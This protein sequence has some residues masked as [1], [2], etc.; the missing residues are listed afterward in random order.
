MEEGSHADNGTI[1][2]VRTND[3]YIEPDKGRRGGMRIEVTKMRPRI[4]R[5]L[6]QTVEM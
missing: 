5:A 6:E 1:F 2:K 4:L 3:G